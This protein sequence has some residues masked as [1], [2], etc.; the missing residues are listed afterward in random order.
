MTTLKKDDDEDTLD[1]EFLRY[2]SSN[3]PPPIRPPP[4]PNQSSATTTIP[5]EK[6]IEIMDV[7]TPPTVGFICTDD[8]LNIVR[9]LLFFR[10]NIF[11]PRQAL[12]S[13]S[14]KQQGG[15]DGDAAGD[16]LG[17]S[18]ALSANASIMAIGAWVILWIRLQRV[19]II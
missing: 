16:L 15:I 13:S 2:L 11:T 14:W 9:W 5:T 1:N 3:I 10:T 17:T 7:D 12:M 19:S 8:D 18:V 6:A 4:P